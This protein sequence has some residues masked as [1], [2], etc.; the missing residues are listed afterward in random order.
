MLM[1]NPWRELPHEAPFVLVEDM[2]AIDRLNQTAKD[3]TRIDLD[4]LPE[5]FLGNPEAPVII[6]G[7]NP[8]VSDE[9]ALCHSDPTFV[10]LSRDNLQHR[11][12]D[13]P[14]Y[15]LNPRV[16]GPGR[17]WWERRLA[18]I[19]RII[20]R[21]VVA[22]RVLCVEYLGY[23]SKKFD[24]RRL[25]LPSQKYGFFLVRQALERGSLVVLARGRQ[26]WLDAVPELR[27]H[28][29][30]FPLRSAQNTAI[31]PGNC[32]EGFQEIISLLKGFAESK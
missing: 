11:A 5:P 17:G 31:T 6:L 22:S 23:H 4:L 18:H 25:Q 21:N 3:V 2:G 7:L 30:V 19:L 32:P 9:D 13:H 12:S 28:E 1:H 29:R 8:G 27:T 14:F 24:H 26:I 16:V 10:Q 20:P 15:L